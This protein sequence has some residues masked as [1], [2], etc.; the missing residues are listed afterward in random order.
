MFKDSRN[1]YDATNKSV[2]FILNVECDNVE[3]DADSDVSGNMNTTIKALNDTDAN[4][5]N[6]EIS[7]Y[8]MPLSTIN[9]KSDAVSNA[10]IGEK[11]RKNRNYFLPNKL[12]MDKLILVFK[13][14][15]DIN[16]IIADTIDN[17][18]I[19]ENHDVENDSF[20]LRR[21]S[22]PSSHRAKYTLCKMP[23]YAW[24]TLVCFFVLGCIFIAM[25]SIEIMNPI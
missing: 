18:I 19:D 24:I 15:N 2:H 16:S 14:N 20:T 4:L 3:C 12:L 25:F 13:Y 8:N 9:D 11:I 5:V 22:S 21:L 6:S 7:G 1:N 17:S 10:A 23:K